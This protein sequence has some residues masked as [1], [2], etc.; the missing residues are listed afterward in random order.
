[1][2]IVA[3]QSARSVFTDGMDAKGTGLATVSETVDIDDAILKSCKTQTGSFGQRGHGRFLRCM[4]HAAG[5]GLQTNCGCTKS[6]GE[7]VLGGRSARLS[8]SF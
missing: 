7:P 8:D 5:C 1:M 4:S 6:S 2:L 3:T